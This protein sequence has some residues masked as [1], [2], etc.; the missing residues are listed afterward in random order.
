MHMGSVWALH[1]SK[2]Q[3]LHFRYL[4]LFLF[5]V[6]KMTSCQSLTLKMKIQCARVCLSEGVLRPEKQGNSELALEGPF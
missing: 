6:K 1:S 2:I 3:E 5:L 4:Y